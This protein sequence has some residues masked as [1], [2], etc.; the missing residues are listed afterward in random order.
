MPGDVNS[1]LNAKQLQDD[2]ENLLDSYKSILS[3]LNQEGKQTFGN[4]PGEIVSN[5]SSDDYGRKEIPWTYDFSS[6]QGTKYFSCHV[7]QS[8]TILISFNVFKTSNVGRPDRFRRKYTTEEALNQMHNVD[9]IFP[10]DEF[11]ES[12]VEKLEVRDILEG[13]INNISNK[14]KKIEISGGGYVKPNLLWT[15]FL[16]ALIWKLWF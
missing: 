11:N 1:T 8:I 5:S 6:N 9:D 12:N 16:V 3:R 10:H 7:L 13:R 14:L 2:I 15:G 4:M